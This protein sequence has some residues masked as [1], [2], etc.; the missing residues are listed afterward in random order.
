MRTD[1]FLTIINTTV[2][3]F[4][5]KRFSLTPYTCA[6][7]LLLQIFRILAFI[8]LSATQ[9][10][11]SRLT[12][13]YSELCDQ[14][15]IVI[16]TQAFDHIESL[17]LFYFRYIHASIFH[18]HCSDKA[19]GFTGFRCILYAHFCTHVQFFVCKAFVL[20]LSVLPY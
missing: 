4:P 14:T 19:L 15:A 18:P 11:D 8:L 7:L 10:G 12:H 13:S 20:L 17:S 1:Y 16:S 2:T 5:F 6:V 9:H 3:P